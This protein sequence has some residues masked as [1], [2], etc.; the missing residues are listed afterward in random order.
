MVF[1][2]KEKGEGESGLVCKE[3]ASFKYQSIT[4]EGTLKTSLELQ[5]AKMLCGL[6]CFGIEARISTPTV[7]TK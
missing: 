2:L 4:G 6:R 1:F 3:A 5:V 7:F